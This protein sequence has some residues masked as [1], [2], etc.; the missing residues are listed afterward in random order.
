MK[1]I[2]LLSLL[3][4]QV[5]WGAC[6][7]SEV[8]PQIRPGEQW[9]LRNNDPSTLLWLSPTTAPTLAEI[10]AGISNCPNQINLNKRTDAINELLSSAE[11]R[12]RFIRAVMLVLIDENNL[13]RE[14]IQNFK[15]AVS[16]SASLADL[17]T[18]VAAL[19]DMPDRTV[20]QAKTAVQNKINSGASD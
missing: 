19:P 20:A 11:G 8:L 15:S 7:V 13:T 2:L 4:S 12:D 5:A 16:A 10:N 1:K 6:E 9:S 17:K 3:L 18:R 14:W